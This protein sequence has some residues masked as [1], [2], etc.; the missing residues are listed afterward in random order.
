MPRLS[1]RAVVALLVAALLIQAGATAPAFVLG[2][3]PSSPPPTASP[4]NES[5]PGGAPQSPPASAAPSPDPASSPVPNPSVA[6]SP[7]SSAPPDETPT[8]I[9]LPD[10]RTADSRTFIQTD[11][12]FIT[13]IFDSQVYYQPDGNSSW[14]PIDTHFAPV[15]DSSV[16]ARITQSPTQISLSAADAVGGFLTL[17][18]SG[19]TISFGLPSGVSPGQSGT[20]AQLLDNGGYAE[21]ANFLPGG[22]GL[23]IFPHTDGFKSFLVLPSHPATNSFSLAI[24]APGL[25]LVAED[26][27]TFSF[28]DAQD[29]VVGRIPRPFLMDSSDPEGFGGGLYSEAVTMTVTSNGSGYTL[30]LTVDPAYLDSAVYPLYVDPTTTSFPDDTGTAAPDTFASQRYPNSNFNTYQRPDSPYYYEMWHGKEPTYLQYDEAFVRF[31][32]VRTTLGDVHVDQA[33]LEFY[34]YWQYYHYQARPSWIRRVTQDWTAGSLTWNN[35]PTVDGTDLGQF[36]TTEG[37]WSHIDLSDFVQKVLDQTWDN[38]GFRIDA[39]TTGIGDWKRIVSR[40]D[41]HTPDRRPHFDISW[42]L[43]SATPSTPTGN[44]WIPDRTLNWTYS[45]GATS[46][47]AQTKYQ[48]QVATTSTGFGSPCRDSAQTTGS[49]TSWTFPSTGSCT[50]NEGTSY[51]WRVSVFDG[52]VWSNWSSAAQFRFDTVAPSGSISSPTTNQTLSGTVTVSGTASDATSYVKYDLHYGAGSTPSSWTLITSNTS[53]VTNGTLASWNTSGLSGIYTL[54]LRVYDQPRQSSGFTEVTRQVVV[55]AAAAADIS[56]PTSSAY[57]R[58]SVTNVGTASAAAFTNYTLD[59]GTGCSPSSWTAIGTNPRTTPVTNGTLGTWTT[60]GLTGGTY[61]IRLV[62]TATGSS[63][64]KTVCVTVD[65]TAPTATFSYPENGRPVAGAVSVTGSVSDSSSG[66][67]TYALDYGAG[68]TPSTW[69]SISTGSGPI[70][71]GALGTW[72]TGSLQGVYAVRLTVT[73]QA[74]NQSTATDVVYAENTRRGEE[75]FFT[76][77]PFDLGGGWRMAVGV[78]NGE[79]TLDRYLFEIPSYGPAQSLSMSYSSLNTSS[80]G[81]FGTGWSSNLTQFLTF[82]SGF[83]VWHRADGGLVPFGLVGSTWTPLAG[84]FETMTYDGTGHTYTITGKDQSKLVFDDSGSG[85]L[86][87]MDNRFGKSLTLNW[88]TSPA[89]ATDASG[90][91][92]SITVVSGVVTGVTDSAGRAWTFGYTSGK[93]TT[94]TDPVS[95]VTSLAYDSTGLTSLTRSRSRVSGSAE[96]IVWSVAY[97]SGKVSAVTDPVNSSVANTFGYS[98]GQTTVGLLKEYSGPVRNSWTYNF[99]ALGRVTSTLDPEGYTT[100]YAFDTASN[101]TQLV[102]PISLSPTVTQTISYTYDSRGN[103]LTQTAQLNANTNVVTAM[104]YNSTNDVVTRSEADND[105][106]LKLVTKYTYDGSGHLTSVDINC[107]TSGTTPPTDAGTCTGAG[108]QNAST[109]LITSFG[110]TSHDELET[111]TDPRGYVTKHVYDTNGNETETKE[112]FVSGQSATNERNVSTVYTYGSSTAGQAGVVTAVTDPVGNSTSYTY[113]ALGRELTEVLPGDSSIPVLIPVLT[114]STTYDEVGNVLTETDSWTGVTRITTHVYDKANRETSTTDPAGVETSTNY[115]AAGDAVSVTTGGTTTT[116]DYDGLGRVTVDHLAGADTTHEYDGQG[117]DIRT[118]DPKGVETRRDYD[119]GGR[120]LSETVSAGAGDLVTSYEYDLLGRQTSSDAADGST[121][122]TAFDRAGR[123]TSTTEADAT[124]ANAFD[125][126]SNEIATT[127]PSGAVTTTEYDP[128]NRSTRATNDAGTPSSTADDVTTTSY[129]DA[130]GHQVASTDDHGISGISLY[131]V[132][133]LAWKSIANCTDSGTTP[134][135]DPANCTGGGTHN[136]TFNVITTTDYDGAGALTVRIMAVGNNLPNVTTRYAYDA[137]GRQQAVMDPMGTVTRTLYDGAGRVNST[138]LNCTDDNSNPAPPSSSGSW[139]NC[140]GSNINDGTWNVTGSRT[141]DDHG[142]VASETAPNGRLTEYVYDDA[143]RLVQRIDNYVSNPQRA[144]ENISTYYAYDDSGRQSAVLAPTESRSTYAVTRYFYDDAGHLEKQ[145]RAC[146]QSGTGGYSN[147]SSS[148]WKTCA[149]DANSI[150]NASTNLTTTYGY[151]DRGDRTSVTTADP[152]ATSDTSTATVT[153]RYAFDDQN[154]LC[155]VLENATVPLSSPDP[156]TNPGNGSPTA[157][158]WTTYGYDALGNMVSMTDANGHTTTYGYDASG[159]QVTITDA[160]GNTTTYGYNDL[161]QRVSQSRR[162]TGTQPTLV[163]WSYDAAGRLDSRSAGG[164]TTSYTY[165]DNGNQLSASNS[166]STI[167]TTYDRLNRPL[168]VTVDGDTGATTTYSYDLTSPSWTDPSGAYTATLDAFGR[169]VGLADPVNSN[170]WAWSYRADGQ[171]SSSAAPNGNT[172]DFGYDAAGAPASKVTTNS[173]GTPASYTWTRN[174]AG[175]MLTEASAITG[176]STNGTTTYAYD[177]LARLADFSLGGSTTNYV[178]QAVTNR[179]SVQV[180]SNLAVTT[181]FDDANRPMSDSGGASFSSDDEGRLT[182][183]PGQT[184]EW[185][186]LGRL[187]TVKNANTNAVISAYS[188]DALDRL[189]MVDSGSSDVVRFRYVGLT[190]Q[191]AAAVDQDDTSHPILYRIANRW[192]GERMFE[193]ASSTERFYGTN[194]HRDITWMAD[195]SGAVS[196]TLRYDPWGRMQAN[197]GSSVPAFRF[198]SS[199]FDPAVGLSWVVARWYSADLGRFIS[200]DVLLGAPSDPPSRH[201]YSYAGGQPLERVDSDGHLWYQMRTGDWT[202][203]MAREFMGS[204]D[205]WPIIWNQNRNRLFTTGPNPRPTC[206][207]IENRYL[208]LTWKKEVRQNGDFCTPATTR[209]TGGDDK[210]G[211]VAARTYG[212]DWLMLTRE[213]LFSLTESFTQFLQKSGDLDRVRY[214][215]NVQPYNGVALVKIFLGNG[216]QHKFPN[217]TLVVGNTD[218]PQSGTDAT[219]GWTMG[220]Y[221]F[222]NTDKPSLDLLAHE[223]THVL[224]YQGLGGAFSALYAAEWA[225]TGATDARNGAEAIAYLWGAWTLNYHVYGESLPWTEFK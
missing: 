72:A 208:T 197:S 188:Y 221:I 71:A 18:G 70:S 167:S 74:G 115:D 125:R 162:G 48:A 39:D 103:V 56:S 138:I 225:R 49:G 214:A 58:G 55:G 16:T 11:G 86:K 219:A 122:S 209:T 144:D 211:F 168:D 117:R 94:V 185:D 36:D 136:A 66:S 160:D 47:T 141:Y 101:L 52:V 128:L 220:Q 218:N 23:R 114:R 22:I 177:P 91:S 139:W 38:Y 199:W 60:T 98:T 105:S 118:V 61:T 53:Q 124:T 89:T 116:R 81:M 111:E 63:A 62:T 30:T 100:S 198:Q 194:G 44:A 59:Y 142:N 212:L 37:N 172:T 82:E 85:R 92:T 27:G 17:A 170:A 102:L 143:N 158:V 65:N 87:R 1:A 57:V 15:A 28:R 40:D 224:Q 176:D 152:S 156:C 202:Q 181:A 201:L 223:Y 24:D 75:S 173:G 169:E 147:P 112:N 131:N 43:P 45:S 150:Y 155:G 165:D 149:P 78:A 217:W 180:D 26:D 35:R 132:R 83:V 41:T 108:T 46:G 20:E 135:T 154:R 2:E 178:W 8:G 159:R 134:T 96:S 171:V 73:D 121:I 174:R 163:S 54:R 186:D 69:T 107:T 109:N 164:A 84:H 19:R 29:F 119:I 25:T 137:A 133:G 179:S 4:T 104:T 183:R 166:T 206:V 6:P 7:T 88:A 95:A 31:K 140:D 50:M 196:A 14:L 113:D 67:T 130:A 157:N 210:N 21:Y 215:L 200:E 99:D 3:Q 68:S 42:H 222:V 161:G 79:L 195:A 64:T 110:Y 145:V 148:D 123:A 76:R 216:T 106:N 77:V 129:Y 97:S 120:M 204:S 126:A 175:E 151:D 193:W 192:T 127:A 146:V 213:K 9:E 187:T 184:L 12:S 93:L 207:W 191:V 90:R 51:W 153:T 13:Q 203:S 5:G 182:A 32:D 33:Y 190:T 80:A 205:K 34:P 10:Q 189:L